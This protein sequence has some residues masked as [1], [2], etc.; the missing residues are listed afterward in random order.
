MKQI[1]RRAGSLILLIAFTAL[2]AGERV[3]FA[4]Q[5]LVADR[6]LGRVLRYSEGGTFL[7]TLL[8]DPSLGMGLGSNDGG[9]PSLADQSN[10]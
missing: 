2:T 1:F 6:T 5:Y 4:G 10:R 8:H 9:N 7:G 3:I